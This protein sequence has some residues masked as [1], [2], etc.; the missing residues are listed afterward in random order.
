M[1]FHLIDILIIA[2]VIL[3]LF[4]SK[5]LQSMARN[6]GKGLGQAKAMKDKVM[7]E[8]PVEEITKVTD[9]IPQIPLNSRQAVQMLLTSEPAE[10]KEQEAPAEK[11]QETAVGEEKGV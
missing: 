5:S 10:K 2:G 6:A 11:G 7:S 4:G 8:L 3:A 9:H 1:G